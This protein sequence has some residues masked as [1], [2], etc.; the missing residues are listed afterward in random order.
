MKNKKLSPKEVIQLGVLQM[1][2]PGELTE[3]EIADLKRLTERRLK[4]G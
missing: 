2:F 4:Y 1:K 3:R